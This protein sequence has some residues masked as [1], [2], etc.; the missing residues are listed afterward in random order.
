MEFDIGNLIENSMEIPGVDR[1]KVVRILSDGIKN[2][3]DEMCIFK[4]LYKEIYKGKLLPELCDKWI[5][6]MGNEESSGPKWTLEDTNSVI[7]RLGYDPY[8]RGYTP[9]EFRT[10][11]TMEY[12]EHNP[13]LK[14]SNVTLEPTGWGRIADHWLTHNPKGKLVDDFFWT[15]ENL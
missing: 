13:P 14:K 11:M 6:I 8:E 15:V 9:E 12:Y 10:V 7:K 3:C 1:K 5:S 2:K 4:C